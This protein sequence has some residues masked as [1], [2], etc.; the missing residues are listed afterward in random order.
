MPKIPRQSRKLSPFFLFPFTLLLTLLLSL[1]W[2]NAKEAPKPKPQ[3]WQ[4]E[5]IVAALD[6]SQ[7]T[8]KVYYALDQLTLYE[9]QDLKSVVKKPEDI[10]RKVADILKD[11]KVEAFFRATAAYTLRQL[12][13][14]AQ[15]YMQDIADILKDKQEDALVRRGA[16]RALG[17][18]GQAAQPYMQDIADILKDEQEDAWVRGS[19]AAALGNLGQAAQPY[20]RD[21]LAFLKN[22][23]ANAF[24]VR[25]GPAEALANIRKLE[26]NEVVVVLNTIYE[27]NQQNFEHWRFLTYFL[28]GGTDEVKTLLKWVGNPKVVPAQLNYEE[29]K[30]TLEVF[31]DAWTV[32]QGLERLRTDLANKIAIVAKQVSWKPQDIPLLQT[33]Y[34]NLKKGG[35]NQAD[36]VQSAIANLTR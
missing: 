35:Y 20:I 19:A 22:E 8:V 30:K 15:P 2:V 36:I 23:K 25:S 33:H 6:D 11:E 34:N 14:A 24:L 7:D 12:G 27:P 3:P 31:R 18:L 5:G 13:Q 21:I 4:I 26:L 17:N 32:S 10:A 1:P 28:S 29:A 16:A 9:P